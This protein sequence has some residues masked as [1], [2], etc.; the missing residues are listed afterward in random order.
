M[1]THPG[2]ASATAAAPARRRRNPYRTLPAVRGA[3]QAAYLL[4][5]LLAGYEF[6]AFYAQAVSGG[7]VTAHRP[8][9]VEGFLPISAL[10]A[11]KRLLLTGEWDA[12]HPAGLVILVAAVAGSFV[13]R[14]V[15]CSWIC[16]VGG[17][18]RALAWVGKKTLWRRRKAETLLPLRADRALSALKYLLL[19]FFL[20]A[21]LLRMDEAAIRGFMGSA[22]NLAAD[23]KMLLFFTEMSAA[24]AV[25]LLLLAA[26]SVVVKNIW[27][28]HLCPYGALLGLVSWAS[29]QRVVRDADACIDCR[30]CTKACPVEIRVHGKS[31]VW[32][33][34]CTGC[35]SCVSSCPVEDCLTVA[36]RGKGSWSPW[37]LPAVGL[38]AFYAI[39]AAARLTGHWHT[40]LPVQAF[41]EAYRQAHA[42]AHP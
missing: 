30:A 39:W 13:A 21:V 10:M 33:P 9:A 17:L 24:T 22:Y 1:A 4:F 26:L 41:I 36:R 8:A 28:R 34:E 27:C 40:G 25:T 3:V 31:S 35:M 7:P 16:P 2:P 32:S 15:F 38:G 19:A 29:P 6:H 18:S 12:I 14:K 37:L 5:V 11:L 23:A 42:L 20:W